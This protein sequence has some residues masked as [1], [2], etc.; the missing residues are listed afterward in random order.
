MSIIR[1]KSDLRALTSTWHRQGLS[2]GLVPTSNPLHD[3][4]LSLVRTA[5]RK[6]DRV[7][8]T[9]CAS[10]RHF[11]RSSGTS[12]VV[13]GTEGE[14]EKAKMAGAHVFFAP[15]ATDLYPEGFSARLSVHMGGSEPLQE[16][17]VGIGTDA[18]TLLAKLLLG[19]QA[20]MAFFGEDDFH[21]LNMVRRMVRDMDI[22]VMIVGCP[23]VRDTDGLPISTGT[24]QLTAEERK[25]A[26]KLTA[27]LKDTARRLAESDQVAHTMKSARKRLAGAGFSSVALELRSESDLSALGTMEG[28]A[29]LVVSASLG[30]IRLLD[31]LSVGASPYRYLPPPAR[32]MVCGSTSG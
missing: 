18:V 24:A 17:G 10:P 20:D 19:S 31:N 1:F 29:R 13:L 28:P 2:I 26:S 30:R 3:G 11:G 12:P 23:I 8:L 32:R 21:R 7:I 9:A 6:A 14:Y 5:A 27:I 25:I 22:P 16:D 15:D 4:Q